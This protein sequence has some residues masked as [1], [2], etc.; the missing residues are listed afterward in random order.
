MP[1]YRM[2]VLS[3][4]IR[5]GETCIEADTKSEAFDGLISFPDLQW[6]KESEDIDDQFVVEEVELEPGDKV[7]VNGEL[8]GYAALQGNS[9]KGDE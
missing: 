2:A 1:Y 4:T 8:V 9:M 3:R 5:H 7:L 6:E